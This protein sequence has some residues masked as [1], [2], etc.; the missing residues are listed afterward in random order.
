[1][2][3]VMSLHKREECPFVCPFEICGK[4]FS[5][6]A[7]LLRHMVKVHKDHDETCVKCELCPLTFN[8][9]K[10]LQ[11]HVKRN[12]QIMPEV[13]G[14]DDEAVVKRPPETEVSL[15]VE[16]RKIIC[17]QCS[18]PFTDTDLLNRHIANVHADE[19]RFNCSLC[20]KGFGVKSNFNAHMSKVH[21]AKLPCEFCGKVLF[22]VKSLRSHVMSKHKREDCPFQCEICQK[23]F[24]RKTYLIRHVTDVHKHDGS[25]EIL[26]CSQCDEKT[27]TIF[28]HRIL[29]DD[30]IKKRHPSDVVTT[31]KVE[32]QFCGRTV[33]NT[34]SLRLHILSKHKREDCPYQCEICQKKFPRNSLML[35]H[36]SKVHANVDK[37]VVV[38]KNELRMQEQQIDTDHNTVVTEPVDLHDTLDAV[39]HVGLDHQEI[40]GNL[41]TTNI[42]QEQ[43]YEEDPEECEEAMIECD[44]KIKV[45]GME[46][47]DENIFMEEADNYEPTSP[48]SELFIQCEDCLA[49]FL[50]PTDYEAHDCN[51]AA[52]K[53]EEEALEEEN[54]VNH[55]QTITVGLTRI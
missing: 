37:S 34:K 31:K 36:V 12:H 29:L 7:I 42:K 14:T 24:S 22:D 2:R 16:K 44:V 5:I 4:K 13:V 38:S 54:D 30:H 23:K 45:E 15:S 18:R 8:H 10:L 32:C 1:M 53:T 3:H 26:H 48:G 55:L 43:V 17:D 51:G 19:K 6:H 39:S 52:I 41:E 27:A 33:T 35:R 20:S 47:V 46:D 40:I 25:G 11:D 9:E 50:S 28:R 49:G 21:G